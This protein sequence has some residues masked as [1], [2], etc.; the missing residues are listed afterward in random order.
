MSKLQKHFT[1]KMSELMV[2]SE[3]SLDCTCEF[4]GLARPGNSF[5]ASVN[6]C[7]SQNRLTYCLHMLHRQ[8]HL[9]AQIDVH[10]IESRAVNLFIGAACPN[11]D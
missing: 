1:M 4:R 2:I 11:E 7:V 5:K 3:M 6:G 10:F 9:V 8:W